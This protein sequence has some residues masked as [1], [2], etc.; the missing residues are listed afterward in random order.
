MRGKELKNRESC[1][2]GCR[3]CLRNLQKGGKY[4][5]NWRR[6]SRIWKGSFS[7]RKEKIY[8]AQALWVEEHEVVPI[9]FAQSEEC[10][11]RTKS[12]AHRRWGLQGK[13]GGGA[14]SDKDIL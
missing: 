1:K 3:G 6:Q 4:E 9:L 14:G 11:K 12:S 7:K 8:L 13:A 2:E 5:R 10:E